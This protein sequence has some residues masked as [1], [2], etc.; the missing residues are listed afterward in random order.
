MEHE[1]FKDANSSI[2]EISVTQ[3]DEEVLLHLDHNFKPVIKI[4]FFELLADGSVKDLN[5]ALIKDL[6]IFTLNSL[7]KFLGDEKGV[8]LHWCTVSSILFSISSRYIDFF[9][10]TRQWFNIKSC[11]SDIFWAA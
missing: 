10:G 6:K 3:R 11:K 1:F 4:F 2:T 9:L 7:L 8:P 5:M